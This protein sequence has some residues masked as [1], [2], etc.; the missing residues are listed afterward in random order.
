MQ[1]LTDNGDTVAI[2]ATA[3]LGDMLGVVLIGFYPVF[4]DGSE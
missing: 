2:E 1:D 4:S 3:K